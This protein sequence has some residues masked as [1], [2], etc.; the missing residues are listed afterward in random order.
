V[1]QAVSFPVYMRASLLG[2]LGVRGSFG[3]TPKG[4][5]LSLPLYALW[6]Q[7]GLALF[8][9]F[10]AGWGAARI[11]YEAPVGGQVYALAVNTFW[12]LYHAA[13]LSAVLYFNH[14]VQSV[15][16]EPAREREA[17]LEVRRAA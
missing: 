16:P 14:P 4:R 3:I 8:C 11:Y 2:I 7:L 9:L 13:V 5:S 12:C 1:L 15:D 17:L 10:A 6:A